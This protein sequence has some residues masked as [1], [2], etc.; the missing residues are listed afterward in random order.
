MCVGG[1]EGHP[2]ERPKESK[3]GGHPGHTDNVGERERLGWRDGN[4]ARKR[5]EIL[6]WCPSKQFCSL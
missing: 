1:T 4:E 3:R 6:V 2:K 5:C